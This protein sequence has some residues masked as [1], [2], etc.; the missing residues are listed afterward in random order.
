MS[1]EETDIGGRIQVLSRAAEILRLLN[2]HPNGLRQAARWLSLVPRT[3]GTAPRGRRPCT[4]S[5][6]IVR[7]EYV[8]SRSLDPMRRIGLIDQLY[9]IYCE[10][11]CGDSREVF[12]A[13]VFGAGEVRVALFYGARGELGGYSYVATERVEHAG[14]T[15]AV[16]CAGV[17]FRL[18][19]HGGPASA[20]FGLRHALRFKLR[21]P[22]T[23]LAYLTRST[24]PAVY[25]LL[26]ASPSRAYPH[27]TLPTPE[28]VKALVPEL[29]RRRGYVPTSGN[30]WVVREA[31]S[32][33]EPS[34]LLRLQ[35]DPHARFYTALNPRYAEGES[36]LT[37]MPLD[38]ANVA[39]TFFR[40]LRSRSA[41]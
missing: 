12:E 29:T 37:W 6:R 2:A 24:T 10:T 33:R 34:R 18:G 9:E 26:A 4:A 13:L 39:C 16:F 19:Y 40:L 3:G 5:R 7:T 27:P 36:L 15:Y 20:L 30:P 14:R 8:E 23:P 31:T 17:F 11:V 25:R 38:V 35:D 28:H 41:R 1:C 32:L 21:E 22:F